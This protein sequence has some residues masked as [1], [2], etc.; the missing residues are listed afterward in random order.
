MKGSAFHLFGLP[1][2]KR[3]GIKCCLGSDLAYATREMLGGILSHIA[4]VALTSPRTES[5]KRAEHQLKMQKDWLTY[6]NV[7]IY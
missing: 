2:R 3:N 7:S 5:C 1:I 6:R 4:S